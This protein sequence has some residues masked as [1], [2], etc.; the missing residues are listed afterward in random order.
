MVASSSH[1]AAGL[2]GLGTNKGDVICLYGYNSAEYVNMIIG[3][4]AAGMVIN[5]NNPA[6]TPCRYHTVNNH[7]ATPCRH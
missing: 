5:S 4:L 6:A 3:S 2:Q 1:I 7:T